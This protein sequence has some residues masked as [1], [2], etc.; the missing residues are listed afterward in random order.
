MPGMAEGDAD[1]ALM[2]RRIES[3]WSNCSVELV[4]CCI[5]SVMDETW[6]MYLSLE[7]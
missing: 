5:T 3:N 1:V 6:P 2:V 4:E 7:V